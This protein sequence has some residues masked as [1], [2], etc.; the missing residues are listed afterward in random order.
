ARSLGFLST[1]VVKI[2]ELAGKK[3]QP[4]GNGQTGQRVNLSAH[5]VRLWKQRQYITGYYWCASCQLEINAREGTRRCERGL[6][7]ATTCLAETLRDMYSRALARSPKPCCSF[8]LV[9]TSFLPS[10]ERERL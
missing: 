9:W 3:A 1:F 4:Q 8:A 2:F 10:E 7:P 5:R 6:K